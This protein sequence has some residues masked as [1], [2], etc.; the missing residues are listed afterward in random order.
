MSKTDPCL[1]TISEFRTPKPRKTDEKPTFSPSDPL[2]LHRNPS[3]PQNTD[4]SVKIEFSASETE[5][6]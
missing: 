1:R 3:R 5:N 2:V 4:T 6:E